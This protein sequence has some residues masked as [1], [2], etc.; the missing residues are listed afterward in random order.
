M[1]SEYLRVFDLYDGK[2]RKNLCHCS[3]WFYLFIHLFYAYSFS[4]NFANISVYFAIFSFSLSLSLCHY[5]FVNH[6]KMANCIRVRTL[7]IHKIAMISS[8]IYFLCICRFFECEKI[9]AFQPVIQFWFLRA[10]FCQHAEFFFLI[11]T[12]QSVTEVEVWKK[13]TTRNMNEGLS[14]FI[15]QCYDRRIYTSKLKINVNSGFQRQILW[16]GLAFVVDV[17]SE[18]T[19]TDTPSANHCKS[20]RMLKK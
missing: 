10:S 11:R 2:E 3:R 14:F 17:N 9:A 8:M 5:L 6:I 20:Q 12:E 13:T 16:F 1:K 4:F 7:F 15:I 18:H 19:Y